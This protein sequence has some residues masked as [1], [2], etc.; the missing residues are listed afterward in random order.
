MSRAEKK[1]P[2][3]EKKTCN[4]KK[5][6]EEK[7][8]PKFRTSAMRTWMTEFGTWCGSLRPRIQERTNGKINLADI[9]T[10]L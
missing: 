9:H 8:K 3:E 4:E 7:E 5:K 2:T 10:S 1:L 6:S